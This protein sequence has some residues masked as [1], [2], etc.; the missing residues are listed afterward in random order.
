MT[1]SKIEHDLPGSIY[2]NDNRYWWKVKQPERK[3][4]YSTLHFSL[5]EVLS[6]DINVSA[7]PLLT[8]SYSI[9]LSI[10]GWRFSSVSLA[11]LTRTFIF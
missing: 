11:G 9:H 1:Q 3:R 8:L 7:F 2:K 5:P 10:S 4:L 6:C